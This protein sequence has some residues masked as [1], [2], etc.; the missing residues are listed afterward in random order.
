MKLDEI[1]VFV[2]RTLDSLLSKAY[3]PLGENKCI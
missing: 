1:F 3:F 2:L